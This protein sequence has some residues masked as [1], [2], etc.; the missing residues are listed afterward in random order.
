M[1]PSKRLAAFALVFLGAALGGLLRVAI[2]A[3]FAWGYSWEIVAINIAGSAA[4]GLFAGWTSNQP[5]PLLHAFVAPGLLG[6]F[7]TFSG[8]AA[9][10]WSGSGV[11]AH[12]GVLLVTT[13]ASVA[14]AAAGWA[15]GARASQR[16]SGAQEA[17]TREAGA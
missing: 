3:N 16:T 12:I 9:F 14:S 10:G 8:L 5:R 2:D 17:G 4:L 11:A 13:A 6:G 7:T 1:T 15:L